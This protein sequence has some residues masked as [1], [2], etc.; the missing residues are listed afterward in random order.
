[1]SN[2]QTTPYLERA[3]GWS[4]GRAFGTASWRDPRIR[5]GN[6][7]GGFSSP[8]WRSVPEGYWGSFSHFTQIFRRPSLEYAYFFSLS[9]TPQ[10]NS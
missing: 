4:L 6:G 3:P 10:G 1:M 9:R 2:S 8:P 7:G 5:R